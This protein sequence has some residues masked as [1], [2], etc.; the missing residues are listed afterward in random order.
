M[1]LWLY[2]SAIRLYGLAIHFT[3]L[4]SSK[5]R[6]IVEG[7]RQTFSHIAARKAKYSDSEWLWIHAASLGE[8]EQGRYLIEQ[9]RTNYPQYKIALSF[10][11]PSGYIPRQQYDQVDAVFYIPLD[12]LS[13]ASELVQILSP[14][15]AIFIKYDFWWNHLKALQSAK[16][17]TVFV[18]AMIRKDQYFIKRSLGNIRSILKGVNHYYVQNPESKQLLQSIGINQSTICGDSRLDSIVNELPQQL[19]VSE[20]LFNWKKDR[21]CIIYGSVHMSDMHIVNA[22]LGKDACHLVVPHDVDDDNIVRI[23]KAISTESQLCREAEMNSNVVILAQTGILRHI[24]DLADIVYIGGGFG[25][26]I[27]NILEPLVQ[28]KP[29]L[30]GPRYD[31]FPEAI[32]LTKKGAIEV[33]VDSQ[34]A[35]QAKN[36]LL[37]KDNNSELQKQKT[38][39]SMNTGATQKILHS[40]SKNLW[41]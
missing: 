38:Y 39:I 8:F 6:H 2:S 41:I 35:I 32:V 30:I 19:K 40:L 5:A 33:V 12:T 36:R 9:L 3:A 17:P 4:F 18:S 26:G 31:K 29:I 25:N 22:M 14:K 16:I 37:G 7:R 11:S 21:K 28:L 24:Y 20:K 23:Q 34:S 1:V 10:Y 27:H 13:K 15:L